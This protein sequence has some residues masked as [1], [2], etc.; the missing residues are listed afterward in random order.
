MSDTS[1]GNYS[2]KDGHYSFKSE[3]KSFDATAVGLLFNFMSGDLISHGPH[4]A[5]L[6]A[7][8]RVTEHCAN[9]HLAI[10]GLAVTVARP[11]V[12]ELNRIISIPKYVKLWFAREQLMAAMGISLRQV[13]GGGWQCPNHDFVSTDYGEVARRSIE[14]G[15]ASCLA[16][17]MDVSDWAA[18]PWMEKL[19]TLRLLSMA[20]HPPP[21]RSPLS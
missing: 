6:E 8:G 21:D 7:A 16:G 2:F 1:A 9:S 19:D 20:D 10:R 18:L 13:T 4:D 11:P 14:T 3:E 5:I 12:D 17:R 15:I